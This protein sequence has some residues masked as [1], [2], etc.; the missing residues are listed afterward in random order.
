MALACLALA[1]SAAAG[2]RA[3]A[4]AGAAET[5]PADPSQDAIERRLAAFASLPGLEARFHEEKRIALLQE[6]LASEGTL[7]FSPPDRLLRRVERPVE[8][9][10][11]LRGSELTLASQ[12]GQRVIDLDAEPLVRVFVDSFRLILAGDSAR[13]RELYDMKLAQSGAA[14]QLELTPRPGP[15]AN[16]IVS[17][18]VSGRAAAL[19]EL[20]VLERQGDETVTRFGDVNATRRYSAEER[21]ELFRIPAP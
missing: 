7:R 1:A 16:L 8:S 3:G 9:T 12:G 5:G 17:V 18:V 4:A 13:L 2:D 10:L 6:P 15:L 20:R 21:D 14:W 11:L 19:E